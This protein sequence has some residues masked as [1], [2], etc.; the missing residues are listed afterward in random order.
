MY[1]YLELSIDILKISAD[2]HWNQV[3][4]L[5]RCSSVLVT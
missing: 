3:D 5:I 4:K 2:M 1:A